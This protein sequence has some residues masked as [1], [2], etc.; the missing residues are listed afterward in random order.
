MARMWEINVFL[1]LV[2]DLWKTVLHDASWN[3]GYILICLLKAR[4][5][6]I[7]CKFFSFQIRSYHHG[8]PEV[9]TLS[10]KSICSFTLDIPK[11]HLFGLMMIVK[12]YISFFCCVLPPFWITCHCWLLI[13]MFDHS[14][15]SK[16]YV[17]T[18]CFACD[19]I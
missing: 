14:S 16:N 8:V 3:T 5:V 11:Y 19:L 17:Y 9:W 2:I 6:S 18:V 13:T 10:L 15:Y 4:K 12:G 1:D 7:P